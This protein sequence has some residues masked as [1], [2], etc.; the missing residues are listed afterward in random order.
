MGQLKEVLNTA[1]SQHATHHRHQSS[2]RAQHIQLV[3]P[4]SRGNKQNLSPHVQICLS[5]Y[6]RLYMK[7]AKIWAYL[8]K[9]PNP[10]GIK[11]NNISKPNALDKNMKVRSD[12]EAR[13]KLAF[14]I[15]VVWGFLKLIIYTGV[16]ITW[17]LSSPVLHLGLLRIKTGLS[18]TRMSAQISLVVKPSQNAHNAITKKRRRMQSLHSPMHSFT[19][20]HWTIT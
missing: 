7:C 13:E 16:K 9:C 6:I 10:T 17:T 5:V 20:A 14:F 8:S 4:D 1:L 3:S 15:K 12:C 19:Y 11:I 18:T 2:D